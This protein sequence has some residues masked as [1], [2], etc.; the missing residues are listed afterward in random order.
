MNDEQKTV[1]VAF[2]GR[3]NVGKSSLINGLVGTEISVV[4]HKPQ[5]TRNK[6]AAIKTIDNE[7]FVFFDTP[8][9]FKA[10]DVLGE[11]M[12]QSVNYA[13]GDV[14]CCVFVVEPWKEIFD[15]EIFDLELQ[16][17]EKIKLAK[18]PSILVVNKI[19]LVKDSSI[20]NHIIKQYGAVF[21]FSSFVFVSA[22]LKQG[23]CDLMSEIK[24]FEVV[25]P[26]FFPSDMVIDKSEEFVV[27]EVFRQKI[28]LNL[29]QEVPHSVVVQ[30]VR[31]KK[32]SY[33]IQIYLIIYCSKQSHKGIIIGR[34]GS[35][36]KKIATQ[37]RL[38]LERF[39]GCRVYLQCWVK[40]KPNWKK[41][42][43]FLNSLGF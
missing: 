28:L 25:S 39:F 4:S 12:V 21:E 20:L 29:N 22:K 7:Q 41:N 17:I 3:P 23:F 15:K 32:T 38:S 2:V 11:K 35:L 40:V 14:D 6:I 33:G 9:M 16:L 5:T 31:F 36:L 13:I 34:N 26:H 43:G 42:V 18:V 24:K 37:S 27:A 8:G 1:F 10:R 19:D 30:V